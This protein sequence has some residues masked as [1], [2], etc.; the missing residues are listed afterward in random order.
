MK[1]SFVTVL[2]TLFLASLV[3]L[4]F[5]RMTIRKNS[6]VRSVNT[7]NK[8][9]VVNVSWRTWEDCFGSGSRRAGAFLIALTGFVGAKR[10]N[11]K[12]ES[13]IV[14][15][16]LRSLRKVSCDS[17]EL[18]D[19]GYSSTQPLP[20]HGPRIC[21]RYLRWFVLEERQNLINR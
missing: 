21:S 7:F 10:P 13:D 11:K 12:Y 9:I 8:L 1:T 6:K 14:S 5:S 17:T 4:F 18:A 16:Y 19:V 20:W 2:V 3:W 15:R